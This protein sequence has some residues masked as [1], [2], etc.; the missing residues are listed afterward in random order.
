MIIP[1]MNSM[2]FGETG[3]A[4]AVVPSGRMRLG[5]PGAPGCT[6]TGFD[7]FGRDAMGFPASWENAG[8]AQTRTST[9]TAVKTLEL[10]I[11]SVI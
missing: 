2:S 4:V 5:C 1:S 7:S 3:G 6:I 10:P 11:S 8:N 9:G